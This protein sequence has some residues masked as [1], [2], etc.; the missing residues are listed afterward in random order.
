MLDR[1]HTTVETPFGSVAVKIGTWHGR[2]ITWAPEYEECAAR[3]QE[4]GVAVR[5]V[6][7]AAF[8]AARGR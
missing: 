2:D 7:E 6:Y 5:E 4:H 3:A 8:S 1:R